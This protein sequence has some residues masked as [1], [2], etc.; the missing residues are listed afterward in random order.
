MV[1][2]EPGLPRAFSP[3]DDALTGN[4]ERSGLGITVLTTANT[5]VVAPVHNAKVA[6]ATSA[7][8]IQTTPNADIGVATVESTTGEL[9]TES[10]T[11]VS[12]NTWLSV[13]ALHQT[14][15]ASQQ[16]F[17]T[18]ARRYCKLCLASSSIAIR[19]AA[20]LSANE[21]AGSPLDIST[22]IITLVTLG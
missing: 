17:L 16:C 15:D 4:A 10:A 21:P 6:T 19:Y 13:A 14:E 9:A 20:A 1:S 7:S 3:N 22:A 12:T 8:Y 18:R 2:T 11:F 5:A